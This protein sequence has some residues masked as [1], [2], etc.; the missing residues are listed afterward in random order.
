M[1]EKMEKKLEK[2]ERE[3]THKIHGWIK[4]FFKGVLYIVIMGDFLYNHY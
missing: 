3:G 4:L 1:C 2:D